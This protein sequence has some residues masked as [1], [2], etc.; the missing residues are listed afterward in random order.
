MGMLFVSWLL[1]KLQSY[2]QSPSYYTT[3][4]CCLSRGCTASS[5]AINNHPAIVQHGR[6]VCLVAAQQARAINN[7]PAI[8][9]HGRVVCLVA[10]QQALEI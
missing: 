8:V 7:H 10:A 9:Q 3:W 5:R 2:K 1:G 6:V 4:T